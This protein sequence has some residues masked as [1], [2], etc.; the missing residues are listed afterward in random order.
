MSLPVL[1][2]SQRVTTDGK[3]FRLGRE[4]FF[5][6]GITYGPFAPGADGEAFASF[7]Q[8]RRDFTLVQEL[9]VNVLRVYYPP[10]RWL[11]DLAQ[12]HGLKLLV[13]I[14]WPKHLCFLD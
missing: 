1:T 2:T 4:K 12:Q 13:D 14:P 10:P 5:V 8:T 6:K 3:F 9:G 11:L 7:E